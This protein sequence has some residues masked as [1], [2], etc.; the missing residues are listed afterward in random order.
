MS[1]LLSAKGVLSFWI[2]GKDLGEAID[3]LDVQTTTWWPAVS[4]SIGQHCSFSFKRDSLKY[5]SWIQKNGSEFKC[6]KSKN[7][8]NYILFS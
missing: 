7:F 8:E 6:R 3:G 1:I 2:N 4:L 5:V